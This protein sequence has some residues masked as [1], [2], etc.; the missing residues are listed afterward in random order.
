MVPFF[1]YLCNKC[2][3]NR[4]ELILSDNSQS[5]HSSVLN[6]NIDLSIDKY[7]IWG[8]C[9]QRIYTKGDGFADY[10]GLCKHNIY[11]LLSE[12]I[13]YSKSGSFAGCWEMVLK[14]KEFQR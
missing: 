8:L 4:F 6:V 10:E 11:H 1:V 12:N 9:S 3:L 2:A 14:V 13:I 7:G 5:S